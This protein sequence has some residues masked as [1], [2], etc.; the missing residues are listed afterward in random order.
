MKVTIGFILIALFSIQ[1]AFSIS[2]CSKNDP[3]EEIEAPLEETGKQYTPPDG[4][5]DLRARG[6]SC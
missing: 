2:G 3:L 1:S 6:G 5:Q 4:C